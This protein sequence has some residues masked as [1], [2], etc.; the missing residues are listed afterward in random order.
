[1]K[2]RTSFR[3]L[4]SR[5]IPLVLPAAHDALSARMIQQ[6]G[7][8]A[9]AVGGSGTLAARHALPD[10]GIAGLADLSGPAQDML[11]VTSIACMVDGDDGYGD[12]KSVA[13][14]VRTYEALGAGA[15]VIED[16]ARKVK[17]PGQAAALTVVPEDEIAAKLRVAVQT[18]DDRDF[19]LIG[20]TDA[21]GALGLDAALRRGE[22]FLRCGVDGLFI[23]GVRSPVDLERVGRHFRGTPL[24]A[25][26]Y[27]G[28]GGATPSV[29]ELH[30]M[31]Y[32]QIIHPLALLLPLCVVFDE[33][34]RELRRAADE[35]GQPRAAVDEARGR[36][37]LASA[38]EL[39]PWRALGDE[40]AAQ[41]AA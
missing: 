6:A 17:R 1:M 18:R 2:R 28:D 33:V 27:G 12:P 21:F 7:F 25:V 23:A 4:L 22:Q 41:G 3:E 5:S 39:D 16:Q 24:T 20:R 37:I 10:I 34:L 30:A 8:E 40:A 15:L 35:G 31:G 26:V 14:T 32:T 29:A 9:F 38:V 36:A 13:R 19:W 11:S